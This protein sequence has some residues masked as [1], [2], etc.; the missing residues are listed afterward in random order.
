[1]TEVPMQQANRLACRKARTRDALIRAAQTLIA[2]DRTH[3]PIMQINTQR[4]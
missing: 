4:N 2:E 3:V 1:M